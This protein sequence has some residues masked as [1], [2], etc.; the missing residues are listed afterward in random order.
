MYPRCAARA[1]NT[2]CYFCSD[3]LSVQLLGARSKLEHPCP[4]I[5]EL[6][7]LARRTPR[8]ILSDWA[9]LQTAVIQSEMQELARKYRKYHWP[10]HDRSGR[11]CT[12]AV[13]FLCTGH[14]TRLI[15]GI[16]ATMQLSGANSVPVLL[17]TVEEE[18]KQWRRMR[19]APDNEE[20][21]NGRI[22]AR[23]IY[24]HWPN[25]P[26]DKATL[27]KDSLQARRAKNMV[28]FRVLTPA[29]KR[30]PGLISVLKEYLVK[31]KSPPFDHKAC[32]GRAIATYGGRDGTDLFTWFTDIPRCWKCQALNEY[33]IHGGEIDH[34]KGKLNP[35]CSC[36]EDLCHSLCRQA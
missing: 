30:Y 5:I 2:C 8:L 34:G 21:F 28:D 4:P 15:T 1:V 35:A 13:I 7:Y 18:F 25:P 31:R 9:K 32:C 16:N 3:T 29:E 6:S 17:R 26:A 19:F 27:L 23:G 11:V 12:S 14:G 20:N 33:T 24:D 10:T 22:S 36:A